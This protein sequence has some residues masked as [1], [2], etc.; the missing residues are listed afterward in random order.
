MLTGHS[1]ERWR[2]VTDAMLLK[3]AGVYEVDKMC[4][5]VLF[6]AD[7]N[8]LNKI[9]GRTMMWTAEDCQQLAKEQ[10]GSRNCIAPSTKGATNVYRLTLFSCFVGQVSYAAMTPNLV[11]IGLSM[12]LGHSPCSNK[13]SPKTAIICVFTTLQNLS[14]TIRT[15]YGNSADTYGGS[16][17]IVPVHD[18]PGPMHGIMQGNGKGPALW[19]VVSSPVLEMLRAEGFGYIFKLTISGDTIHFVGFR[20]VDDTVR[21]T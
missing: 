12:Q 2:Q 4:T 5:I 10:Y 14:H 20:F 6:Q 16:L 17:W 7:F 15:A 1:P 18:G 8:V 3:K 11:T 9:L 19:A 13:R 21:G